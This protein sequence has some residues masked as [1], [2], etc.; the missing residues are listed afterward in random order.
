MKKFCFL[1]ILF[2]AVVASA[3]PPPGVDIPDDGIVM[4]SAQD[5]AAPVQ[6]AADLFV[7]QEV[8]VVDIGNPWYFTATY[9]MMNVQPVCGIKQS[10]VAG[11][12]NTIVLISMTKPPANIDLIRRI[13]TGRSF[14]RN[15]QNSNYGYP[16]TANRCLFS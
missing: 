2:F 14:T 4:V 1:L 15:Q 13:H 9:N 5:N 6:V 16:F 7:A 12:N 10:M 8:A 11:H 3:S